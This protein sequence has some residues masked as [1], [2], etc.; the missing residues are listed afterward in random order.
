MMRALLASVALLAAGLPALSCTAVDIM[1]VDK[2]VV[3]GRTMEWAFDMKWKL[4]SVPKGA[5]LTLTAPKDLHLPAQEVETLYPLVGIAAGII[6]GDPLLE[7]QNS[8]GL[9]MSGN[10]LPG[11]TTYQSVTPQDKSTVEI[12]T[13][14]AWALGRFANVKDLRAALQA[15]K[16]WSDPSLATGPTPPQLHFVFTDRSGDG[17]IVEYVDG[18]ARIHDNVAHVLTNA[19]PYPWHLDN[20]RNYLSLSTIGVPS[21]Q[22]GSVDVTA[23]GQGGGLIGLPGDYTPPSRFVRAAF[24]RHGMEQP[25]TADEASQ[26]V[27]HVLNTVDIPIGV[28]QS[29]LPDGSL[30]SD[31]TQWVSI[32][33]LTHNRLMI[34]DYNHRLDYLSIDL[35]PIF[36]RKTPSARLVGDLPYP[37]PVSGVDALAP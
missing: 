11:F 16:V 10:F 7:G 37:K 32:K 26:S 8:E 36:A 15:T 24:V 18:E 12:L 29:R 9:G 3:A 30:I 19:P 13:F 21:R 2:S 20:L 22:I 5:K 14:G 23:V 27:A 33:D 4:V 28:A 34:A 25:K 1:A 17:I 6:A 35:D 31:Y